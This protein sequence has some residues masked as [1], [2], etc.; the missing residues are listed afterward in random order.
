MFVLSVYFYGLSFLKKN[1]LLDQLKLFFYIHDQICYRFF[2]LRNNSIQ[3]LVVLVVA[4][5]HID[6]P[7]SEKKKKKEDE[8]QPNKPKAFELQFRLLFF[9]LMLVFHFLQIFPK[10]LKGWTIIGILSPAVL[11]DFVPTN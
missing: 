6:K 10:F 1:A 3:I 5:L 7:Q 11:H 8:N 2:F 4:E 9:H